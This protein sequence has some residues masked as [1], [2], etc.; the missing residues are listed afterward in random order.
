M[1]FTGLTPAQILAKLEDAVIAAKEALEAQGYADDSLVVTCLDLAQ[2][3]V[4]QAAEMVE[5][6]A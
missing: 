4:A 2:D 5:D 3:D 6:D 1:D